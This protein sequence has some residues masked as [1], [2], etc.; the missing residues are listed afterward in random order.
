MLAATCGDTRYGLAFHL[1]TSCL[2]DQMN[3]R[4]NLNDNK[5]H[6]RMTPNCVNSSL[7]DHQRKSEENQQVLHVF[8]PWKLVK[9]KKRARTGRVFPKHQDRTD[10]LGRTDCHFDNLHVGDLG[11]LSPRVLWTFS[12]FFY[13]R[14][15]HRWV[16][17]KDCIDPVMATGAKSVRRPIV[18]RKNRPTKRSGLFPYC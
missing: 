3:Q 18:F 1:I 14:R 17:S 6:Q 11:D 13:R 4:I 8:G 7:L 15:R 9:K 12:L 10:M 2:E 16:S 5:R